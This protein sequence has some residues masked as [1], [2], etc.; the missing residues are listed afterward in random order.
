[1]RKET[2]PKVARAIT[3]RALKGLAGRMCWSA[4]LR[5]RWGLDQGSEGDGGGGG[6]RKETPPKVAR[7]AGLA[8][9]LGKGSGMGQGDGLRPRRQSCLKRGSGGVV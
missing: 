6:L 3:D 4:S 8:E 2:P 7:V 5:L 9:G 1:M